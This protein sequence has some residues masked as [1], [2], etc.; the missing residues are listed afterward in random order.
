MPSDDVGSG[1]TGGTISTT[2]GAS[3]VGATGGIIG[4][5][6]AIATGGT[7]AGGTGGTEDPDQ[8]TP[9]CEANC[10]DLAGDPIIDEGTDSGAPGMFGG[11]ASGTGPCILEPGDNTLVPFNWLRPRVKIGGHQAGT[12]YQIKISTP[13]E[14]DVLTAYTHRDTWIIPPEFW[15]NKD[16]DAPKGLTYN[17]FDDDITVTVRSSSGGESSVKFKIAPVKAGGAMVFW[18]STTT[19]PGANTNALYGFTPGD[20]GI[21]PALKPLDVLETIMDDTAGSPKRAIADAKVGAVPAGGV[22][23]VGCHTSTP[24]GAAVNVTDHWPWNVRLVNIS[25]DNRGRAP[26]YVTPM[27]DL[28]MQ[29]PWQ[30]VTTYSKGDWDAGNR[31]YVTSFAP[32]PA[33]VATEPWKFWGVQCDNGVECPY[34]GKDELIWV[35]LA[36]EGTPPTNNNDNAIPKALIAAQGTGWGVIT[37]TGDTAGAVLP[38]FSHSG[39]TVVYTSTDATADGH[40]GV[41]PNKNVQP[42]TKVDLY[43]VPFAGGT[44]SPVM[45]A[46]EADHAE[47]YPDYAADDALIAFTRVS[48]F[49]TLFAAAQNDDGRKIYYRPEAEVY[50]VKASGGTAMRLD[51]NDPPMCS[52]DAS[53][54]VRNAWPKWSPIVRTANGK[55]Y[56]FLVFSSARQAPANIKSKE[57][58]DAMPVQPMSQLYMTAIVDDGAG[59]LTTYG[60]S[61]LWNQR[62]LVSGT[63]DDPMLSDFVQSNVTPA[64]D[65]FQAPPVPPVVVVVK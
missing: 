40:V 50:V 10:S 55:K 17:A 65:E 64:W 22:R 15:D 2:G 44:A 20:E 51:A 23:C 4:T 9:L 54:G 21:V 33:T 60:A 47:Y 12:I 34:T 25:G 56:Y 43:T 29:M 32:R 57:G 24:D 53:P 5:G 49:K 8:R 52:G 13:K 39:Q 46:A 27:G 48:N 28:V 26:D 37:R 36:A 30:G 62:Y 11:P 41:Q 45:G 6:G 58:T 7:G 63:A 61:Y 59:N 1:A 35:N 18:S 19:E 16:P 14:A 31:R 3:S 38:D 42:P